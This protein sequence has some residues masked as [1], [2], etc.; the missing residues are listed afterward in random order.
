MNKAAIAAITFILLM[1]LFMPVQAE[2][3]TDVTDFEY[4]NC[5]EYIAITLYTGS[6][7]V[8]NVPAYI[9]GIPVERVTFSRIGE[10]E[11]PY[12][13][14]VNLPE[15][16]K[17]IG[18]YAFFNFVN[19]TT[20][21]GLEYVQ[22]LGHY[23]FM[24]SGLKE[25][26][27][28]DALRIA[29]DGAFHGLSFL[30][31]PDHIT[32]PDEP[33]TTPFNSCFNL[34]GITL[35]RGS[36]KQTITSVDSVIYS[37]DMETLV[38]HMSSLPRLMYTVPD[39]VKRI[40]YRA[41]KV[42]SIGNAYGIYEMHIPA[43][44]EI[45]DAEGI[46][47]YG[48]AHFTLEEGCPAEDQIIDIC[49]GSPYA[50]TYSVGGADN[51][52]NDKINEIIKD[53]IAPG[54]TD[55]E[56]VRAI[57]DWYNENVEYDLTRFTA[58][59]VILYGRGLCAAQ[60]DAFLI[61]MD[62]IGIECKVVG[63]F[64]HALNA[65]KLGGK[66]VYVDPTNSRGTSSVERYIYCGFEDT[67]FRYV[68][69]GKD[70]DMDMVSCQTA[71]YHYYYTSGMLDDAVNHIENAIEEMVRNGK[72]TIDLQYTIDEIPGRLAAAVINEDA[73]LFDIG[74][75]L[76]R[77]TYA[78]G[79]F[80]VDIFENAQQAEFV[81][82]VK[83]G[84][85]CITEYKGEASIVTVPEN[86]N[87][88][89]VG[90]I[91]SAFTGKSG[92][93]EV[94]LP[95]TVIDIENNAFYD[96]MD[97]EKI[98]MP[99]NLELIGDSA[100]EKCRLL[101]GQFDFPAGLQHIGNLAFGYCQ[102][103]TGV[104]IPSGVK[105]IGDMAFMNC[106]MLEKATLSPGIISI[107]GACFSGCKRLDEIIIPNTVQFIANGCFEGTAI[108][109]FFIPASVMD[110]GSTFFSRVGAIEKVEIA[111]D[112]PYFKCVDDVVYQVKDGVPVRMKF[113]LPQGK[114]E[115][116]FIPDTVTV[117]DD[118]AAA[119][120][121]TITSVHIPAGME[122]I[123]I[124]AFGY[125]TALTEVYMEDGIADMGGNA[126]FSNCHSLKKIRFADTLTN[127]REAV[128][129]CW[130]LY[131][132]NV[133][134]AMTS[135]PENTFFCNTIIRIFVHENVAYFGSVKCSELCEGVY[136]IG[137]P[138]SYAEMRAKELGYVFGNDVCENHFTIVDA[139]VP[140]THVSEGLTEGKHCAFC[141]TVLQAQEVIPIVEVPQII[142]P[143]ALLYIDEEAFCGNQFVC[144][145]LPDG[146]TEIRQGAF[147]HCTELKFI[148][149]PASVTMI[150]SKAFEGCNG[151]MIFVTPHGSAAESF[152]RENGYTYVSR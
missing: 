11:N 21:T 102:S 2:T 139:A 26:V 88:Y 110:I 74:D 127:L 22:K 85:A 141:H 80:H 69:E 96:C 137:K 133:P 66:W 107:N 87:G 147:R 146:C 91:G 125:C 118:R 31:I 151:K 116:L 152:A 8:V 119:Y 90:Y 122:Y 38:F 83:N 92:I 108:R 89:T 150:D 143:D 106:Y 19:M 140:A 138:G 60:A 12:V 65:V 54:M 48:P 28:S 67:V 64:N 76:L 129:G 123:G 14:K 70:A 62:A 109:E 84:Y 41:I 46:E 112:N 29:S 51:L 18:D 10:N 120:N 73:A 134:L 130:N 104:S 44:V 47:V 142:L 111:E 113:V 97:L 15:T 144:V 77:C 6:D 49:E 1:V 145:I 98:N 34:K 5:G 7:S 42:G 105:S 30:T 16:V 35:F 81:Y 9:D 75:R 57:V 61:L 27:F 114:I 25:A 72:N 78:S 23:P 24:D 63:N 4:E 20:I 59:D 39:Q 58:A 56:K 136:I 45:I 93:T 37:A 79:I 124:E 52:V 135:V 131:E 148:E 115:K 95:D 103:I 101:S 53:Y 36:E 82:E 43:S 3:I 121:E 126:A 132:V 40:M 86:I 100:F 55:N 32:W 33:Y 99:K 94:I 50:C 117:I 17:E 128:F 71:K 68:W 13:R 149:I